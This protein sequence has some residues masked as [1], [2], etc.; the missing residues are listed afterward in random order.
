VRRESSRK[1]ASP[2]GSSPKITEESPKLMK[3]P[4]IGFKLNTKRLDT[5]SS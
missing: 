5:D 1:H 4:T 3:K 2:Y